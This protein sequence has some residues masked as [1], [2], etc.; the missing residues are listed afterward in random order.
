[1][2][3]ILFLAGLFILPILI[4]LVLLVLAKKIFEFFKPNE[5]V[6]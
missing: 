6:C 3:N 1:M 5:K 4:A 2:K